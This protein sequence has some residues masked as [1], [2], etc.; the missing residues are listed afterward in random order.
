MIF[1]PK[2]CCASFLSLPLANKDCS[3]IH[4]EKQINIRLKRTAHLL[5]FVFIGIILMKP[6][7]LLIFHHDFFKSTSSQQQKNCSENEDCTI[8][9][10]NLDSST[11]A[12]TQEVSSFVALITETIHT[13]KEQHFLGCLILH[14]A[15]R[16]PP[17]VTI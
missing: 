7:H 3:E 1:I 2:S 15:S 6:V 14:T 13:E 16:A 9:H 4:L 17:I 11:G 8:C 5:M 12:F 10:F